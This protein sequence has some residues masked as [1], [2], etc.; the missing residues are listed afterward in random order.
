MRFR[1]PATTTNF[2]SGFDTFGL[3]LNLHNIFEVIESDAFGVE[4]EGE[5]QNLPR[6]ES[7]LLVRVY[8][9]ACEV[10]GVKPV[11]FHLKQINRVPTA[12]G[13]GS[14]AT[15]IVGGIEV[16]LRKNKIK[17]DVEDKLRVAFEF[18]PHPDNLLPAFVGG[19]VVCATEENGIHYQRLNFPE[20]LSLVFLIPDFEL[21]TE[22][23]RRVIPKELPL[24]EAVFNIQRASLF[25]AALMSG[26][27][28]LLKEAVK[29]R[30]HQPHRSKL[31]P[32]FE[33]VLNAG[34]S[35]GAYAVFLSGAGPTIGAI[36][37]KNIEEKVSESMRESFP[38]SSRTLTLQAQN[39]GVLKE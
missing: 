16:A 2:G 11:P 27:Y 1:V 17:L 13:L 28:E 29:D 9:R 20:E 37:P 25:V 5:G 15:A 6:D 38:R 36:C 14:S 8:K 7:N 26:R 30:L 12:R 35:S 39:T 31:I 19:F 33:N 21:S 24:R 23:A 18:E 3:A 22:E 10:L 34:Y 4:I 32:G